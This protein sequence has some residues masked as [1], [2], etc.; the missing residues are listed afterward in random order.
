MES[1]KTQRCQPRLKLHDDLVAEPHQVDLLVPAPVKGDR[2]EGVH[3]GVDNGVELL[4]G[5]PVSG[6]SG[7]EHRVLNT[8]EYRITVGGA[9]SISFVF[10][11]FFNIISNPII[12]H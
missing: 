8:N 11:S 4:A 7:V 12:V 5:K 10:P 9:V 6:I 3:G 2:G 1:L